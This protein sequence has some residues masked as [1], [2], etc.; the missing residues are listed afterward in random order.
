M[1]SGTTLYPPQKSGKGIS[2]PE[3]FFFIEANCSDNTDLEEILDD[4]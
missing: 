1:L 3:N 2:P 4:C